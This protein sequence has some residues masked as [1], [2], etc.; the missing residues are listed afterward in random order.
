M[1]SG[2][3]CYNR[4]MDRKSFCF[5]PNSKEVKSA[6]SIIIKKQKFSTALLQTYLGKSHAYVSG[7]ADWLEEIKVI[8]PENGQKPREVL[9]SSMDEFMEKATGGSHSTPVPN[10]DKEINRNDA[11]VA[12]TKKANKTRPGWVWA[13]VILVIIVLGVIGNSMKSNT[14]EDQSTTE[15]TSSQSADEENVL[16]YTGV[17]AKSA[18]ENLIL[19]GYSVKFLFDR[20]NNGGFSDEQFQDFVINDSFGSEYYDEMPFVVTKQ[21]VNSKNVILTIEYATAAEQTK[22]Q[23]KRDNQLEKKLSIVTAMTTCELYGK[24]NYRNFKIHSIVGKIAEYA[25]DNDT[26]FLKYTADADDYKNLNMECYVTGTDSS[27]VVKDF[28][29]Y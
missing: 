15:E 2:S 19:K 29:L 4:F 21:T 1:Y 14:A 26:W 28:K 8:G 22:A 5:D 25:V 27:P 6:V 7:L 12:S 16:D 23:E 10:R 18:Y 24:R 9:V 3:I 13:V 11:T 17:D 20:N